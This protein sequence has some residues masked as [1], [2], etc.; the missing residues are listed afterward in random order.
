VTLN[1]KIYFSVSLREL[2]KK[3]NKLEE[4]WLSPKY[5]RRKM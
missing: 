1:V 5:Q 3:S 4:K 2:R